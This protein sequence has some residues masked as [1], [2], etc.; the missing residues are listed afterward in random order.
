MEDNLY[1]RECRNSF[2]TRI[3]PFNVIVTDSTSDSFET[4]CCLD[5]TSS[6]SLKLHIFNTTSLVDY[7]SKWQTAWKVELG[8]GGVS[9]L[10][11][12]HDAWVVGDESIVVVDWY[13]LSNYVKKVLVQRRSRI[14]VGLI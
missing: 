3:S 10:P 9:Y 7:K 11:S 8:P 5:V 13:G 14:I 1:F 4:Y 2:A 12:G 6:R